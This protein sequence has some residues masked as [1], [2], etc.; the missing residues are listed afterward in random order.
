VPVTPAYAAPATLLDLEWS[1]EFQAE[2]VVRDGGHGHPFLPPDRRDA[3]G[4]VGRSFRGDAAPER[5]DEP[6]LELPH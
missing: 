5:Y 4:F 1:Y 6:T 3:E 2:S